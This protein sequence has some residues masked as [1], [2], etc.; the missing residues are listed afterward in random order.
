MICLDDLIHLLDFEEEHFNGWFLVLIMCYHVALCQF[1]SWRHTIHFGKGLSWLEPIMRQSYVKVSRRVAARY[2]RERRVPTK[3][4]IAYNVRKFSI[5]GTVKNRHNDGSCR[6]RSAR[7]YCTYS[8]VWTAD[9]PGVFCSS[10]YTGEIT[11][12]VKTENIFTLVC[13]IFI[14]KILRKLRYWSIQMMMKCF[15]Q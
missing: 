11:S 5:H 10:L 8:V 1:K 9:M 14:K 12:S 15:Q 7:S 3:G 4:C 2:P 6:P 13:P